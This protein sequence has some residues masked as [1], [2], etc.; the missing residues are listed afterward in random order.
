[1]LKHSFKDEVLLQ[2]G[3]QSQ[4]FNE[5]LVSR[6][7]EEQRELQSA[8]R[9]ALHQKDELRDL[10]TYN[11]MGILSVA[12]SLES[13]SAFFPNKREA[14]KLWNAYLE[15]ID[16][17]SGLKVL[18]VPTDEV[19]ICEAIN[20]P[21]RAQPED[22]ALCFAVFFASTATFRP[23][24]FQAIFGEDLT[25]CQ[26]RNKTGLEQALAKANILENPTLTLLCALIIYLFAL[27][28]HNSGKG[29]WILNGL[30]IRIAQSLGLHREGEHL[31]LSPFQSEIRR[32]I[33][34]H[35]LARDSRAAEDYG[36]QRLC[37]LRSDA[38][39]PLN[40]EDPDLYEDLMALPP[41]KPTFTSMTFPLVSC[42]IA[43]AVHELA[44]TL[45]ASTSSDP[46]CESERRRILDQARQSV[47]VWL[48]YCNPVVPRQ[49]FALLTSRLALRK[50]DLVSRQQWSAF[51]NADNY[52]VFPKDDDL[53]DVIEVLELVLQLRLD[54]T[55]TPYSWM[56]N[57]NPEYHGTMFLLWSLCIRPEGPHVERAWRVLNALAESDEQI[58]RPS[59]S[60][61][62]MLV[63]LKTKAEK[64]RAAT[65]T[66]R[67]V[68][69][70][71]Q[72]ET[73][74][75]FF[76]ASG[77]PYDF[78]DLWSHSG[79]NEWSPNLND[80]SGWGSFLE[81]FRLDTQEFPGMMYY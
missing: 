52:N 63:A 65:H 62:A 2:K 12:S 53:L 6:V 71:R 54:E 79:S 56:W 22:L 33:W 14:L 11:P 59:G 26:L 74:T 72:T 51:K 17:C 50:A 20:D 61:D 34:W 49:K 19:R 18:H 39:L 10:S 70:A 25:R 43:R 73:S 31:G 9:T 13:F 40:I 24:E 77:E 28:L 55:L 35:L 38:E 21:A 16:S 1:V 66:R 47:D 7:M 75:P 44:G 27:K 5:I 4:Y 8:S 15:R 3:P 81:N 58:T 69:N 80:F 45:A 57:A 76:P 48:A 64:A 30:A 46:P 78:G 32:R 23:P 42:N 29:I 60:M 67:S 37:N 36:L 41:P 68:E